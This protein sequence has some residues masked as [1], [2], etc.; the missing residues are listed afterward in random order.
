MRQFCYSF[1]LVVFCTVGT[2][3]AQPRAGRT[4]PDSLRVVWTDVDNFWRAYDRLATATS[5]AD[6]VSV[7]AQYYLAPATPGLRRYVE[8]A[9]A[10]APDFLVAI[11]THR[12]YLAAI[13]PGLQQIGT[14]KAAIVAAARQLKQAYPA[15]T[16]PDLYFAVG[17]FEVGGTQFDDLL[18]VGAELKCA[19]PNPPLAELRP[20]LRGSISPVSEISTTCVHEMVHAQQQLQ[21][22]RTNLEGALKEGAAE[23]LAYRFTGRLGNPVAMAYGRQHEADV[24][25]AF[26][27][28]ANAPIVGKWFLASPDAATQQPGALAYFVGFRI[29]EA[30]YAEARDKKAALQTLITLSDVPTL[31]ARGQRY[32]G[33][34]K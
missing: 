11:R 7:L 9:N 20:E 30:Y 16:F 22:C 4:T 25:R 23:Y 5:T 33:Q 19:S 27:K 1:L 8:A 14:Q 12:R 28:E 10:K 32:L 3:Q 6:S 31:L 26:A 34:V 15:S 17:K 18:Y 21:N 29:C 13:R 24:R 2:A